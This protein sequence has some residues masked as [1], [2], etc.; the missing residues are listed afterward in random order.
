MTLDL[1][2]TILLVLLVALLGGCTATPINLPAHD[3]SPGAQ[4][5]ATAQRDKGMSVPDAGP[6]PHHEMGT[7]T[8]A[9]ATDSVVGDGQLN[10]GIVEDGTS[11]DGVMD[12]V[13]GDSLAAH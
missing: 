9:H 10:D 12:A 5:S 13:V 6:T 11:T 4:D 2:R 3:G 1:A 7:K 8:D